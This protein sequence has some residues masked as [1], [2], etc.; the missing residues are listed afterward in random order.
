MC[1]SLWLSRPGDSGRHSCAAMKRPSTLLKKPA[2]K[3][4][5]TQKKPASP[6]TRVSNGRSFVVRR[7]KSLPA[8]VVSGEENSSGEARSGENIALASQREAAVVSHVKVAAAEL[9]AAGSE[10]EA[11]PGKA[12]SEL[13]SPHSSSNFEALLDAGYGR[14]SEQDDFAADAA[15]G[16]ASEEGE[17][18]ARE[19]GG[20]RKQVI[21]FCSEAA[22]CGALSRALCATAL[23]LCSRDR[24]SALCKREAEAR[25]CHGR[26]FPSALCPGVSWENI[27]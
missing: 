8:A 23:Q 6:S 1:G 5:Q 13:S 2:S 7:A 26:V 27:N 9:L 10:G 25:L 15:S 17:N 18:S 22:A 20:S 14:A 24:G 21:R 12:K 11:S 16:A 19:A 3:T 4:A